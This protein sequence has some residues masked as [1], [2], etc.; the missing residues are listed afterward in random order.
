MSHRTTPEEVGDRHI[1]AADMYKP[2]PENK[3]SAF[4]DDQHLLSGLYADDEA[5][6]LRE[7]L[8]A[9]KLVH[10]MTTQHQ[11]AGQRC[12]DRNHRRDAEYEQLICDMLGVEVAPV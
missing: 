10:R 9:S 4:L 5:V 11:C 2:R 1:R 3:L 12:A 6:V 7:Q 8:L